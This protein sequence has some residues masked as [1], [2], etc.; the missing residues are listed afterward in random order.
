MLGGAGLWTRED[1]VCLEKTMTIAGLWGLN[2]QAPRTKR[3][4]QT[5]ALQN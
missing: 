5:L 2:R 3:A 1:S 4:F